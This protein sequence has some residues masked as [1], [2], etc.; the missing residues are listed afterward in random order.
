MFCAKCGIEIKNGW[1][2]CPNCGCRIKAEEMNAIF[3]SKSV[4]KQNIPRKPIL[5]K[6]WFWTLIILGM[7]LVFSFMAGN[8]DGSQSEHI[9]KSETENSVDYSNM[10]MEQYLGK[11]EAEVEKAGFVYSE[12]KSGY[13]LPD[14]NVVLTIEGDKSF[15]ITIDGIE[16]TPS[17]HGIK[18]G[19]TLGQVSECLS[20]EYKETSI[21]ND[22]HTFVNLEQGYA[23][24]L[25]I[26]EGI[27]NQVSGR[28]LLEEEI[29]EHK[30]ADYIFPDSDKKYLSEGDIGNISPEKLLYGRNEIFARHGY[31][32]K[33]TTIGA[34]FNEKPWY[35]GTV[36]SDQF[37]IDTVFNDFE[38]KNVELIKQTEAK[39]NGTNKENAELKTENKS[40]EKNNLPPAFQDNCATEIEG[41]MNYT[42][43]EDDG[44]YFDEVI[45]KSWFDENGN[46]KADG[47]P[48]RL[49]QAL[50][51]N[52]GTSGLEEFKFVDGSSYTLAEVRRSQIT[53]DEYDAEITALLVKE[54]QKDE[55]DGEIVYRGYEYTSNEEV[56]IHGTFQG[57]L[58]GDNVLVFGV[59]SGLGWDDTPNF[60]GRYM[61]NERSRF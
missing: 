45:M 7:F 46:P 32:F 21:I 47:Y 4:E 51:P 27:V 42:Y 34:Y 20:T 24:V 35:K 59:F 58:N 61:E 18:N 23:T 13:V 53:I 31:I 5:K 16:N 55:V 57:M 44:N 36:Q 2:I 37:D 60:V 43:M 49:D 11:T 50:N 8:N 41:D 9:R 29:Q 48:R 17:F 30:E 56:V 25:T 15:L 10:D 38:K 6:W 3:E 33:D 22:K 40:E 12:K 28:C 26:K 52:F 19:M 39:L 14:S 54:L 1:K